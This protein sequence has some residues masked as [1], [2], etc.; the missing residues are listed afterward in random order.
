MRVARDPKLTGIV[1][2]CFPENGYVFPLGLSL[3]PR[4]PDTQDLNNETYHVDEPVF[5][6]EAAKA[7]G[8]GSTV[9]P[10]EIRPVFH[11]GF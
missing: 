8:P 6:Y 11:G 9:Q 3:S 10:G 4:S 5:T 7:S 2:D 1:Y